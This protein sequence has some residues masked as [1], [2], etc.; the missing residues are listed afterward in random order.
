[1]ANTDSIVAN[2]P[3]NMANG[4]YRYRDREVRRKYMRDY[5]KRKR[6]KGPILS[7]SREN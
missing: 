5:M 7:Q 1:M 6:Q 4:T 2:K 3:N